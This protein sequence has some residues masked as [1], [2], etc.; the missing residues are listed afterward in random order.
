MRA[1][2]HACALIDEAWG[3]EH[4]INWAT[5]IGH[6]ELTR[7]KYVELQ[8]KECAGDRAGVYDHCERFPVYRLRPCLFLSGAFWMGCIKNDA[9][10]IR[11]LVGY[12]EPMPLLS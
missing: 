4:A 3:R 9:A 7:L 12:A 2:V 8:H 10:D 6:A 1:C 5:W 11:S